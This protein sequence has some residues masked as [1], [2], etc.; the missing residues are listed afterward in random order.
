MGREFESTVFIC[1]DMTHS[2]VIRRTQTISPGHHVHGD[3]N[4]QATC[5]R[6]H[7]SSVKKTN[8]KSDM[9]YYS[10]INLDICISKFIFIVYLNLYLYL[11]LFYRIEE[12]EGVCDMAE[13]AARTRKAAI[14]SCCPKAMKKRVYKLARTKIKQLVDRNRSTKFG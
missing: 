9:T 1:V 14:G 8:L 4:L 5:E 2:S 10:K 6:T 11:L 3:S 13:E 7:T 12:T